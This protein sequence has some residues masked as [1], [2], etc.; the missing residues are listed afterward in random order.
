ML[1]PC[2]WRDFPSEVLARDGSLQHP[3]Y[4]PIMKTFGENDFQYY[5]PLGQTR[6]YFWKFFFLLIRISID[7]SLQSNM[8]HPT[9][10]L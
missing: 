7:S 1:T 5:I 6:L 10:W 9:T 4:L 8:F 2:H 3:P